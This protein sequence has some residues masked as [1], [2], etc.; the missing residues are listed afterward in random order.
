[1]RTYETIFIVHPD[2]AGEDYS[3]VL[4]K[5]KGVLTDQGAQIL[6]VDEWGTRK[7]AY[8]I[9]KQ[10]RGGYV[11]VAYEANPEVIAEFERRLRIDEAIMKFQTVYLEK[12][13][14]AVPVAEEGAAAPAESAAEESSTVEESEEIETVEE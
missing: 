11:L 4:E 13:F 14:E 8:P 1:M 5:F 2:V 7:L 9:K 3:A 10:T 6:K 12:G